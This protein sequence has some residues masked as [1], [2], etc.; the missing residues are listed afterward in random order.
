MET[1]KIRHLFFD[2]DDTL[3]DFTKNSAAALEPLFAEFALQ[4]K[5][6]TEFRL[7]LE[8]YRVINLQFWSRYYKREIDKEYMR[9]FR[10]HEVFKQFGYDKYEDNLLFSDA[11]T[12][13]APFGLHLKEGCLDTL[14]YL[15]N[16]YK[17]H[18]IT[19]GFASTQSIKLDGCKLR[20][21]FTTIIIS[22]E[23][24]L[25]KP[26]E[27]IFRLAESLT[28]ARP[29][30]CVMIGDSIESDIEGALNAGWRAIYFADYNEHDYKGEFI[31]RL[32]ELKTIF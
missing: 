31:T 10:F 24:A 14:S 4:R 2:L 16:K 21:Y 15:K 12:K 17:L 1:L 6:N 19:N 30:E 8:K 20:E 25:I 29:E 9:N 27:K 23:H 32:E 5:L 18:I 13:R 7:F 3:W 28:E 22:D 11:Y 26:E